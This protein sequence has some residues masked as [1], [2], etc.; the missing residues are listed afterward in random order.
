MADLYWLEDHEYKI[1]M[2]DLDTLHTK[3]SVK[4]DGKLGS[5]LHMVYDGDQAP[6]VL[7]G[8]LLM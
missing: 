6:F 4:L 3:N 8:I 5:K 2:V 7:R 1:A